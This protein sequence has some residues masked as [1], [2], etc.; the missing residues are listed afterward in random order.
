MRGVGRKSAVVPDD[1]EVAPA[2]EGRET[3]SVDQAD[4]TTSRENEAAVL[5][6]LESHYDNVL[7][8]L[9]RI[10][11]GTYGHCEVCDTLLPEARLEANPA[12]TTCAEHM[13]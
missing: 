3:D 2:E 4:V 6:A 8:A 10:E 1:W 11:K 7:A 5:D 12:A 13:R 9:R